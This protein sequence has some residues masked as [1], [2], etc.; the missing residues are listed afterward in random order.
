MPNDE[1]EGGYDDEIEDLNFVRS[2]ALQNSED[3]ELLEEHLLPYILTNFLKWNC[4][5]FR[6]RWDSQY[7]RSLAVNEGSFLAEYRVDPGGFDILHDILES[8]IQRDDRYSAIAMG[9]SG[10]AVITTASRLGAALIMLGGGR[11][12]EAMRTHG[13][14]MSTTYDNFDRVIK[15]INSHPALSIDCDMSLDGLRARANGFRDRSTHDLFQYCTGA[16]DGLA[17][18]IRAPS[19]LVVMNQ[20]RLFSGNRRNIV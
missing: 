2:I 18:H 17:I 8:S 13:L 12:I 9:T 6:K 16:I 11:R 20:S 10:S 19:R 5:L 14:S 1:I 3:D 7:L 4:S 15:A